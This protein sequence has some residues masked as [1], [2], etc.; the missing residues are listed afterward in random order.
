M[1][2]PRLRTRAR[3]LLRASRWLLPAALF[4]LSVVPTL[5]TVMNTTGMAARAAA[6]SDRWHGPAAEARDWFRAGSA[7]VEELRP[8]AEAPARWE[9]P[10]HAVD[11]N[12]A[13]FDRW[14]NDHVGLRNLMIRSKNEIDFRLFD[15]SRRVYFGARQELYGRNLID[16][17][18]PATEYLLADPAR[19]DAVYR[20]ARDF[21]ARLKQQGVTLVLLTPIQKPYYTRALMPAF[22]PR[23]PDESHFMALYRRLRA[24]P[25]LHFVD[26]KRHLDENRDK[27]PIFFKQDFHWTDLTAMVVAADA[28]ATIAALEGSPLRW[29]HA[30][31]ADYQPFV[32]SEARFA[33]RLNT[34]QTTIEPQLKKTWPTRHT[35]TAFDAATTGWEFKTDRLDDAALLPAT[36]LYGNSFSDGMLRAGLAEHFSRLGKIS[37]ALPLQQVPA[38]IRGQCRYL[39]VQVLDIQTGH[40]AAL[41]SPPPQ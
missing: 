16:N 32:G 35:E 33:A 28:T 34:R 30:L 36:C 13:R 9:G 12:Y 39:I 40:W 8:L 18:M 11:R 23:V 10:W 21:A 4:A 20:G 25:E 5:A 14:F 24:A 1:S 37:R 38:L 41:A 22:A 31:E 3:R 27:F 7:P 17:E 19:A 29:R 15:S 26:V 2:G 6:W